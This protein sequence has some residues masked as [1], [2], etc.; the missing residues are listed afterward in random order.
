[1]KG[2]INYIRIP[3]FSSLGRFP[4]AMKRTFVKPQSENNNQDVEVVASNQFKKSGLSR[5]EWS[6][7]CCCVVLFHYKVCQKSPKTNST[8]LLQRENVYFLWH[9]YIQKNVRVIKQASNVDKKVVK[10]DWHEGISTLKWLLHQDG[11]ILVKR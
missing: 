2:H 3:T 10:C 7:P 8:P 5:F 11:G 6:L 1:M 9:P 4:P